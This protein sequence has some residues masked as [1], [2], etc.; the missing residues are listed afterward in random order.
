M[1][2]IRKRICNSNWHLL[3][4]RVRRAAALAG[5]WVG[6]LG[7]PLLAQVAA[8]TS[9]APRGWRFAENV[10]LH[11]PGSSRFA[12]DIRGADS[13]RAHL[14]A[15]GG[16]ATQDSAAVA[17]YSTV[18]GRLLVLSRTTIR[19]AESR[20]N[21]H[22]TGLRGGETSVQVV[23]IPTFDERG[24]VNTLD[25]FIDDLPVFDRRAPRDDGI[26]VV[27]LAMQRNL[28]QV[29]ALY[30]RG[31]A[32]RFIAANAHQVVVLVDDARNGQ[33]AGAAVIRYRFD[34]AG[35]VKQVEQFSPSCL[36]AM[37]FK[38]TAR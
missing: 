9:P 38:T 16:L 10:V 8:P 2:P 15:L 36:V 12:G 19:A 34:A 22:R 5:I 4:A 24:D 37:A 7:T 31:G 25:V 14:A 20:R 23:A 11:I 21:G 35:R 32:A 17:I 33:G 13:A 18:E 29:R 6:A 26:R 27:S 30:G 3:H 1:S 28:E